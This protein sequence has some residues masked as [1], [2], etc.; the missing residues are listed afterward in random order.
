MKKLPCYVE[1]SKEYLDREREENS[2]DVEA[3]IREYCK[4]NRIPVSIVPRLGDKFYIDP[5]APY[6]RLEF[7]SENQVNWFQRKGNR[8]FPY[9]EFI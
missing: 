1:I 9:F 3:W 5:V 6:L 7:V 8:E 4:R 2:R